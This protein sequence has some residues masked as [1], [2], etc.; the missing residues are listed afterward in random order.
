MHY[1]DVHNNAYRTRFELQATGPKI[2][3]QISPSLSSFVCLIFSN[4][5][6]ALAD[7]VSCRIVIGFEDKENTSISQFYI[8]AYRGRDLRESRLICIQPQNTNGQCDDG[9]EGWSF[10]ISIS[11]PRLWEADIYDGVRDRAMAIT[12]NHRGSLMSVCQAVAW[13]RLPSK[14]ETW[15]V[16]IIR[17]Y[18]RYFSRRSTIGRMLFERTNLDI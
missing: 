2:P 8:F 12:R 4:L 6:E 15:P 5:T 17:A 10:R 7:Y 14:V 18:D 13:L 9:G 1:N 16:W 3:A 11:P